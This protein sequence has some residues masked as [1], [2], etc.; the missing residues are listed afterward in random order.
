MSKRRDDPEQLAGEWADMAIESA[1]IAQQEA[2]KALAARK[3]TEELA[4]DPHRDM[5]RELETQEQAATLRIGPR[6]NRWRDLAAY[7][8]EMVDLEQRRAA[9]LEEI[10]A[11]NMRSRDEPARHTAEL[12]AWM[13]AG[14]QDERPASRAAELQAAIADRQAEYDALGI[15]YNATLRRRAD[16]VTK[17]RGRFMRDVA[18]AK[19]KAAAEYKMLIDQLETKRQELLDLRREEVWVSLFPSELL[20]SEPVTISL[21]GAHKA[22]QK[23]HLPALEVQGGLEARRVFD[24]LREDGGFCSSVATVDQFAALAGKTTAELTGREAQWEEEA[25]KTDFVGP[26]FPATW[27][28]SD[29]ERV[30]N[31]RIRNY[32]DQLRKRLRGD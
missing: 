29:D 27:A 14:E 11:L 1:R 26:H 13:E 23:R 28:G 5:V 31:E 8:N 21:V 19:K 6:R 17:N 20:T 3:R 32:A 24:L 2:K 4:P 18:A 22:L 9:I 12:A 15:Q 16:H 7:E 10:A 25:G 30:Q